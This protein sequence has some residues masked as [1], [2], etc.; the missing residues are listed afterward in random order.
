VGCPKRRPGDSV[1]TGFVPDGGGSNTEVAKVKRYAVVFALFTLSM[2]TYIDRVCISA[3]KNSISAELHL[4]DTAMGLVFGAFALGYSVAQVP[5]GWFADKAGPRV[6]LTVV[7]AVWSALIALTGTA[8]NLTSLVVFVFLFGVGQAGALPGGLRVICNWLPP[9]ERGRANGVL[10]SGTR[11]GAAISFPLVTW[12]LARWQWRN[13]F[14]LLGIFGLFWAFAWPLWF[15]NHPAKPL[16]MEASLTGPNPRLGEILRSRRMAFALVQYFA[17]N[18]TFFMCVSWMLPY[19]K[20]EYHL[21]DSR[22]A[23]YS[24][25]P[26]LCGAA[27]QWI[28]GWA[29]DRIYRSPLRIWSRRLPGMLGLA[30]SAIGVLGLVRAGSIETATICFTMAAFGVDMTISP[31]WVFCADIAGHNAGSVSAAMNMFGNLGAFVSALAFPHLQQLTG[32]A[33]TYFLLAGMLNIVGAVC[34][35]QM[36]S[37]EPAEVVTNPQLRIFVKRPS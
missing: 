15:R 34:W 20:I 16:P 18:F 7:V 13:S 4:T 23:A 24:M 2:L 33:V 17:I 21:T 5:S 6:A 35:F 27:A 12:M 32:S 30:L 11:I 8:W 3:G 10:F 25:A 29:V 28:T 22:A 14:Q 31:S 37:L 1:L 26:L 19:L 36:R 9:E